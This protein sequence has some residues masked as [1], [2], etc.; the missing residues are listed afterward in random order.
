MKGFIKFIAIFS[1]LLL[2]V[3][4]TYAQPVWV[5]GTPSVASTGPLSITMNYGI[6]VTGTVY[7]VVYNYNNTT[8]YSS[9]TIRTRAQQAPSGYC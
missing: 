8:I 6:N 9:S 1:V 4:E 7:I 2:S 3:I 5:K